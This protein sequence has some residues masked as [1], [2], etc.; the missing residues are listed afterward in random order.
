M[1]FCWFG[2]SRIRSLVDGGLRHKQCDGQPCVRGMRIHVIDVLELLAAGL[3]PAQILKEL[4]GSAGR[5]LLTYINITGSAAGIDGVNVM[6]STT[7]GTFV[8]FIEYIAPELQKRGLMQ[9]EYQPGTLREKLFSSS[10]YLPDR[11]IGRSYRRGR[12]NAR[13]NAIVATARR[14]GG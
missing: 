7:P 13:A 5:S 14:P 2:A 10:Q 9:R 6:Y 4:P 1:G 12:S 3:S 11:H 8:D